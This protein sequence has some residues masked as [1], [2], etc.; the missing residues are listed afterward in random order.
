MDPI[1]QVE[2]VTNKNSHLL[3]YIYIYIYLQVD[4]LKIQGNMKKMRAMEMRKTADKYSIQQ[5]MEKIL[6]MKL[7]SQLPNHPAGN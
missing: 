1:A 3:Q 5:A 7:H 4:A 6:N 2:L